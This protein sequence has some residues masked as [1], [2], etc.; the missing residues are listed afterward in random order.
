MQE[1]LIHAAK[2]FV[3]LFGELLFLFT[4]ISFFVALTQMYIS[5]EK[6]RNLLSTPIKPINSV[7]GALLG[8]I[9]PFC[10]CSTIPVLTGLIRSGAPF[11]GVISFLLTSPVLNPAIITL[12]IAFF[13]LKATILYS[14]FVL[15]LSIIMGLILDKLGFVSEV[16]ETIQGVCSCSEAKIIKS[17]WEK[18]KMAAMNSKELFK[19]VFP[20]LMLGAVIGAFI[21][22]AIPEDLL[23]NF[24]GVDNLLAIPLAAVVGIPMYIRTETMIP[25]ASILMGKGVS[26]GVVIALIIGG[27]GASLPELSLL[28]SIFKRK[29]I[30]TFVSCVFIVAIVTGFAF[31]VMI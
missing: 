28:S 7:L 13:G 22:E 1:I 12:F 15:S 6:I 27:A 17:H 24:V 10:S 18:I 8:V 20:Y 5:R 9:T 14:A 2:E 16:K 23:G 31:N 19:S 3:K 25:V 11:C 30:V 4:I 26:A 29:M 21:H